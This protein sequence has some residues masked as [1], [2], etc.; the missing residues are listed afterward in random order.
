MMTNNLN[1]LKTAN[2]LFR[3]GEYIKAEEVYL[4]LL[5]NLDS[6]ALLDQLK[7][8][9]KLGRKRRGLSFHEQ[10]ISGLIG[11][12]LGS[13]KLGTVDVI[14][15]VFNALKD[16]EKCLLSLERNAEDFL[17]TVYVINDGSDFETSDWLRRF[18]ASRGTF[19]L[20]EHSKNKGYTKAV[21]TGL[22]MS[23]SDYIVTLNSDTVVTR[24]WLTALYRCINSDRSIGIV[25]PLSNAASW[26]NVPT[27]KDSDGNFSVNPLPERF[28]IEQVAKFIR[29]KS[30]RAYPRVPFVNGFCFMM[31]RD[32]IKNVGFLDEQAFPT[33]YGEEND[34]CLR[35]SSLGYQLAIA[36]DAYVYHAKS[37]SFGHEKRKKLSQL[38][39][40]A[41][42]K[43]HGEKLLSE[44]ISEIAEKV[45]VLD[46]LR[47]DIYT[48]LYS[49]SSDVEDPVDFSIE[50]SPVFSEKEYKLDYDYC[51]TPLVLPYNSQRADALSP[52]TNGKLDIG[53]HLH[54]FYV[55]LLDEFVS[56]L[57]N[58]KY[59]YTLYV[60]I[61]DE[62]N[63]N[64]VSRTFAE[65]LPWVRV[66]VKITENRGRDIG[67][68]LSGFGKA[69]SQHDLICHVHSKRSPHNIAKRD[70]RH[71][72][73]RTLLGSVT[74]VECIVK[75][76]EEN[77]NI[78][79][80]F[81]EYHWSLREQIHWGTNFAICQEVAEETGLYISKKST[82][83][84]PA[85]SM[86]WARGKALTKL[87][88]RG[89]TE[90][91]F[92]VEK[93][94]VDGT[95]AHAIERLF[96]EYVKQSGYE[97]IQARLDKPYNLINYFTAR[98][99]YPKLD[100][101]SQSKIIEEYKNQ[102]RDN[103]RIAVYSAIMGGYDNAIAH[104]ALDASV[105]YLMFTDQKMVDDRGFWKVLRVTSGNDTESVNMARHI[106]TNPYQFLP[107]YDVGVWIDGNVLVKGDLK[108]YL[109]LL[110]RNPNVPVFGIPHPIRNCIYK[111]ADAV[112][113]AGKADPDKVYEQ[114]E[115]YRSEG[116]PENNGLV[117]TNF[118][119]VNLKHPSSK[120]IMELWSK[121]VT[122]SCHR[123]Q[124]SLNYVLWKVNASWHPLMKDGMSLRDSPDF[125]YFGHGKN[126]GYVAPREVATSK[127]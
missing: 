36:D 8:N 109:D 118:M 88:D 57:S 71:Q 85:G 60:S 117:E 69:L 40:Q 103:N 11:K 10:T 34:Y 18:C 61:C 86:F 106:K 70:W 77:E 93:S 72:L 64:K 107:G 94:Q 92:D 126:S 19:Y 111:E 28:S 24:G 52:I 46:T 21:N 47:R 44:K 45:G 83:M 15:P 39:G 41:L 53:V 66:R 115:R 97:L 35:A 38:G 100:T 95:L 75:L 51:G 81:P 122:E 1:L 9:I 50:S 42:R 58:I 127:V 84:F 31:K 89:Y 98:W 16:V 29:R 104:E 87:F 6:S 23:T 12:E 13:G 108:P 33:G 105:D 90:L 2:A 68:M 20:V 17:M 32:V 123:D 125:A 27:L 3:E 110:K 119:I 120:Q 76:F 101:F 99:P 48:S 5:R 67:P 25:G 56:I 62:N 30:S 96:G 102:K 121:E 63:Y 59:N 22:R 82:L 54:L 78:G 65:K 7:F 74:T 124:L 14:V 80:L 73:T 26:Q 113:S 37:K 79:M 114:I 55:D 43:K 49:N 116:Y 4:R 112:I 91:D